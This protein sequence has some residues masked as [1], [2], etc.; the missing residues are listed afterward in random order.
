MPPKKRKTKSTPTKSK[1]PTTKRANKATRDKQTKRPKKQVRKKQSTKKASSQTRPTR[2]L[3]ATR[4]LAQRLESSS[5]R[6]GAISNRQ[7]GDLEG[8][9]RTEQSDSQSVDEL[10]EDGNIVEAG[11]VAG[12][13][14]ADDQDA[15][16]VHTHEVAEDDVPGEYLEKE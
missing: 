14:E 16:E 13:E 6:E 12:V 8:L 3:K 15:K 2:K 5:S 9:W 1:S 4:P 10:V 7:S 11:D